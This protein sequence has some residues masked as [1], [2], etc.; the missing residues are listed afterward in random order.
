MEV[1]KEHKGFQQRYSRCVATI[2]KFDGVHLGHQAILGQVKGKAAQLGL[3]AL[4]ILIEPHPEEFFAPVPEQ[5]P[6]RLTTLAEKLALLEAMEVEFVYLLAFNQALSQLSARDYIQDIL[7]DGLGIAAFIVGND[8][9]YGNQ[10]KGDF[11]LL[12]KTGASHDF[13]VIETATCV[14]DGHR[15]SSTYVRRQLEA[16]DFRL[17]ERLLGRPYAMSGEVVEGRKLAADLGFPTCNVNLH[18]QRTPLHGVYAC[19]VDVDGQW[20][21]AAVNIGYRPTVTDQGEALLEAHLLDFSGNLYGRTLEVVFRAKIR[22]E[23]KYDSLE[24]LKLQI[25]LDVDQVRKFFSA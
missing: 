18:R 24:R 7:V 8:F 13:E 25:A 16:A 17:V 1:I 5:C 23:Q 9:R 2:G 11:K 20:H 12:Q 15:V 4:V 10:R 21:P 6:A 3:P 14:V 19:E 22:E